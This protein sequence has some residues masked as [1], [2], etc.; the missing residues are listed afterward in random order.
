MFEST[1]IIEDMESN[2]EKE[3]TRLW[4]KQMKEAK[5]QFESAPS[6]NKFIRLFQ[7]QQRQSLTEP[8]SAVV[9]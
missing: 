3:P 8:P 2:L 6:R 4:L 1:Q 7:S 5:K 9:H